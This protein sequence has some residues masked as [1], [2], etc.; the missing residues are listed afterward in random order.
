MSSFTRRRVAASLVLACV[1]VPAAEAHAASTG[2]LS[3]TP[4][5]LEHRANLGRVGSLTLNNTTRETLRVTVRVRPWI[6]QLSGMVFTDPTATLST[7]VRPTVSSFTI[8]AGAR[9]PVTLMMKRRTSAGSL[10]GNVDVVGKPLTTKGRKGI[11]PQ[12]RLVS[13]LRLTPKRPS[14][15][16]RTGAAQLRSGVVVLPVRNLGNTISPV[17]GNFRITGPSGRSGAIKGVSILPGK[18]VTLG[19]GATRG[20]KPGAYTIAATLNQGGKV[21][22]ARTSFRIR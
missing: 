22:N 10:Y 19:L 17:S 7:F 15:R 12:F 16:L 20:M 8:A 11:I 5:I 14:L 1:A 9:R 13:A 21:T 3:I 2:G 4:A 6:Q 18:L